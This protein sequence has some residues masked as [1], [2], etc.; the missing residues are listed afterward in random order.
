MF[1]VLL[2]VKLHQKR[3]KLMRNAAW[4]LIVRSK[5]SADVRLNGL[6]AQRVPSLGW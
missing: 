3:E 1:F 6:Q 5:P 4:Q 2:S